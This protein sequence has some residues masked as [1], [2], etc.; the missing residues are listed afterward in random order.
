MGS[1]VVINI[2]RKDTVLIA[3]LIAG[4]S[5]CTLAD[6]AEGTE[7]EELEG[8]NGENLNGENLNGENLN[9]ENLNGE[10]LNGPNTGA[11]TIWTS[12]EGVTINGNTLDSASLAATVFSGSRGGN[13]LTGADFLGAEFTAMR[14]DGK[15]VTLRVSS[16]VEPVAPN[17]KW[18]YFVDYLDDD[19]Q[20]YSICHNAGGP[21]AA[22]PLEGTWDHRWGVP[23]GG[24]H[25]DDPTRFTFACTQI[26]TLAKCVYDGYEPWVSPLMA[27]HHQACA[28]ML[29]ADYCGNGRSYTTTGRLVNLYD[30][31][32]I[33]VDTNDFIIEA[34]WDENG[35]RCLTS[36]RRAPEGADIP[37]Y[38]PSLEAACGQ[39]DH[40][41]SG[42]LIMNEIP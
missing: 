41:Q 7:S 25:T 28:R 8:F 21:L 40:F 42:T 4:A 24:S 10:N 33:Q 1:T 37:C 26:G 2:V 3:A 20:W 32:G 12:L 31:I 27:R 34:E 35:A 23:G 16:V 14:G 22:I 29:R 5:A 6:T 39:L 13:T 19:N 15:T 36:H 9:G 11:F 38:D 17:T 30:G 18:N